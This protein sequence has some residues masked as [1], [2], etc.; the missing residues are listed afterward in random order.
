MNDN[1][2]M[3]W[4]FLMKQSAKCI[5]AVVVESTVSKCFYLGKVLAVNLYNTVQQCSPSLGLGYFF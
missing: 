3:V 2:I 5:V 4:A 1:Q